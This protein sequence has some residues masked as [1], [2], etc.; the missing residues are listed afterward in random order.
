MTDPH[1]IVRAMRHAPAPKKRSGKTPEAKV[2][3]KV[4]EFLSLLGFIWFRTNAGKWQVGN[5]WIQGVPE[6]Y[7]DIHACAHGLFLAIET[8]APKKGLRPAQKAYRDRVEANG[9]TYIAPHSVEELRAGLC[10]AYGP[11]RVGEWETE[12]RTRQAAK[13]AELAAL[14][15]R[16][17]Q[18]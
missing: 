13:K 5:Y 14:K 3:E 16:N 2:A 4:G 8:K 15:R 11:Q 6:G 7:A 10:A 9:G 17:G 18:I 12:G 1:A